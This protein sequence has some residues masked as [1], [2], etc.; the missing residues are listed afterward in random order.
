MFA[1]NCPV[2]RRRDARSA[3]FAAVLAVVVPG[4]LVTACSGQTPVSASPQEGATGATSNAP[5]SDAARPAS[6]LA[7]RLLTAMYAAFGILVWPPQLFT[8]PK[9]HMV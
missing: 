7:A 8:L 9:D 2:T 6:A 4:F 1:F 3:I 5:S